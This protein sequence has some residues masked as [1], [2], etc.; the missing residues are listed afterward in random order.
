MKKSVTNSGIGYFLI[1]CMLVKASFAWGNTTPANYYYN[2]EDPVISSISIEDPARSAIVKTNELNISS[3]VPESKLCTTPII[4]V[5][6]V[7][8]SVCLASAAVLTV[9]ALN[10]T[11]YQWQVNMGSG[12]VNVVDGP[13]YS[14]ANTATLS[15]ANVS[16]N[17]TGYTYRVIVYGDCTSVTSGD[18][19]IEVLSPYITQNP[20]ASTICAGANTSFTAAAGLASAYQWQVDNG[21]G[22]ANVSNGGVY[23]GATTT[24]L[25]ITGATAAMNGYRYRLVATGVC[26]PAAVS[27]GALLTVN[28]APSITQSPSAATVCNGGNTSFT[29]AASGAGLTYQWQANNGSGFA[30]ISNGGVYSGATSSTLSITGAT[31][32]MNGYT[33]RAVVSGSCA[34]AATSSAA[35]LTVNTAPAITQNPSAAAACSGGNA[36][37][38]VAASG[39]GLTYQWQANNGSGFATISNGGVYSGATSA[40]LTITGAMSGMDGYAYRAVVSGSCGSPATS[41]SATLTINSA[42]SISQNP[43]ASSICEGGNAS[44]TVAASGSGLNYQ[45]Q[46]NSGSG[47]GNITNGGMYSGATSAT[48]SITGASLAMNGYAYRAYVS[49]TCAPAVMSSGGT[50]TV[51]ANVTYYQDLDGDG[52][53]NPAITSVSCS[54]TAPVGYVTDSGDTNDGNPNVYPGAPELCGDGIDNDLDGSTDEDCTTEVVASLCGT[55]LTSMGEG[56]HADAVAGATQYRFRV[57]NGANVQTIDKTTPLFAMSQLANRL[58]NTTYSVDVA[59]NFGSGFEAY[60]AACSITTPY[61][62]SQLQDAQCGTTLQALN[63][64]LYANNVAAATTYRFRV[65]NGAEVQTIDRTTRVFNLMQLASYNYGTTYTIDVMVEADGSWG[66][67]GAACTVTTPTLTPRIQDAQCGGTI[68]NLST[69]IYADNVVGASAYRFRVTKGSNVQIIENTSRSLLPIQI[70]GYGY[71]ITYGIEVA[72]KFNGVW[73]AYGPS[74]NV[75]MPIAMTKIQASQCGSTLPSIST[76]IYADNVAGA[77]Q[78]RFRINDGTNVQVIDRT[79]RS[80]TLTQ[81]PSSALGVTYA[82]EVA[83]EANGFFGPYGAVCNVSSPAASTKL[84]PSNCDATV[85]PSATIYAI[86]FTGASQYRFRFTQGAN[87]ITADRTIRSISL[88]SVPGLV[89]NTTYTVDISVYYN[90]MWQPYGPACSVTLSGAMRPAGDA[91]GQFAAKEMTSAGV[92]DAVTFPNPFN[93]A[94]TVNVST[95]SD[96][97]VYVTVYDMSGKVMAT[98]ATAPQELGNLRLGE[99]YAAG[100]YQVRL[101][102]GSETKTLN[103]VKQ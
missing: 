52:F 5:P 89:A 9:V 59:V 17:V 16:L 55:T 79:T 90:N 22:Y 54:G 39:S 21:S 56:I 61:A 81:L 70:T 14:G 35:A 42:P 95:S 69:P 91:E 30:N 100:V 47:Y 58:Y 65:T 33:Y 28:S 4:L 72:V 77:T 37:F 68:E 1:L 15:V 49:G 24:T 53:G 86:A 31:T 36:S 48:L 8:A 44:F 34:P 7:N 102:Q 82:I 76:A 29:V 20:S 10:A 92:F 94:F 75:S 40:T 62:Y 6:P 41:S 50:L 11:G 103:V 51:L 25:S 88:P 66:P 45:W 13:G 93:D 83:V 43:A 60:G 73:S 57:T 18:V 32:G 2:S 27:S 23:S 87:V 96:E 46:V 80:F 26:A 71:N 67:Y 99:G 74:C 85:A 101:V 84:Q 78:Y 63:T 64:N 38:T 97:K 3:L 98:H 19:N 12:Y